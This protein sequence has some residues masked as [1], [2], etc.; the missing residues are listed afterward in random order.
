MQKMK[1]RVLLKLYNNPSYFSF[2]ILASSSDHTKLPS[3]NLTHFQGRGCQNDEFGEKKTI[4]ETI[5]ME[6]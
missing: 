1:N 5:N 2:N 4:K 3:N 6:I